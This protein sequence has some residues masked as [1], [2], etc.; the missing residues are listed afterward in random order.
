MKLKVFRKRLAT[1]LAS[2]AVVAG[3]LLPSVSYAAPANS[4]QQSSCWQKQAAGIAGVYALG[5]TDVGLAAGTAVA[6]LVPGGIVAETVLLPADAGAFYMTWQSA[7]LAA[8][9]C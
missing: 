2:G 3:V 1:F 5:I 8:T 7:K 9:R 6:A 4:S